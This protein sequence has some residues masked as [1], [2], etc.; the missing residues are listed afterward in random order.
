MKNPDDYDCEVC[1]AVTETRGCDCCNGLG[2]DR[3]GDPCPECDGW[4]YYWYCPDEASHYRAKQ[5]EV[6]K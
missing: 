4:G 3:W 5:S 2:Q 1:G 6:S